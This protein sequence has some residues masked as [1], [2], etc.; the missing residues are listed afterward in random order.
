ML[1]SG[2]DCPHVMDSRSADDH[3]VG[4]GTVEHYKGDMEVDSGCVDWEGDVPQCELMFAAESDQDYGAM[5]DVSFID[6]HL[7]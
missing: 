5:V 2:G 4:C 6:V 1:K 3:I 7:L